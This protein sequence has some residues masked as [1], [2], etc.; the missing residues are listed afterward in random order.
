[1]DN[2]F[3]R[4]ELF[5]GKDFQNSLQQKHVIV[6]GLGGVGG[7]T[8]EALARAGIGKLTLIDFDKVSKSN[9]NRQIIALN[10]TIGEFKTDLLSKRLKD[11]NPNIK[12]NKITDFYTE[13]MNLPTCDYIADAI[14]VLKSKIS[15]LRYCHLNN[16]PVISSLGA[17]KRID[18]SKLYICDIADIEDRN[19]PFVSHVLYQLKKLGIEKGINVVASREKPKSSKKILEQERITTNNGEIIEFNKITPSSTPFVAP[20]CGIMIASFIVQKFMV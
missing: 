10:S 9:I 17:G 2:I 4:N 12:I 6:V 19:T 5:W 15:L 8:A 18:P 3:D 13:T 7:F 1:M 14:D 16:V 20:V 11:I